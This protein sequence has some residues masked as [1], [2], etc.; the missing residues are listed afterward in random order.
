MGSSRSTTSRVTS[1]SVCRCIPYETTRNFMNSR[2]VWSNES[3]S[4]APATD[5]TYGHPDDFDEAVEDESGVSLAEALGTRNKRFLYVY[6]FG[7]NWEHD[8]VV[9]NI[10]A[11]Y[12]TA[13]KLTANRE[14]STKLTDVLQIANED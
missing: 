10:V 12:I 6:D 5:R 4:C 8:V 14:C 11:G 2:A 9:E 13:S 3:T 7:D 1:A